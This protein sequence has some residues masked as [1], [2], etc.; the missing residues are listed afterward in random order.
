MCQDIPYT[1]TPPEC[2]R[3]LRLCQDIPYTLTPPECRRHLRLCQDILYTLTPPECG[4]HLRCRIRSP[5]TLDRVAKP[6]GALKGR[7]GEALG[8]GGTSE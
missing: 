5:L 7:Q 1:L 6:S 4:R 3:H 2:G 8:L